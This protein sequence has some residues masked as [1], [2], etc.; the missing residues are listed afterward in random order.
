MEKEQEGEKPEKQKRK[1]FNET[2][3]DDEFS[4]NFT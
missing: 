4:V 2:H 3:P 1:D